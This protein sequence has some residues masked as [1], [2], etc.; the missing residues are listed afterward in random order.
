[1]TLTSSSATGNQWFDGVTLLA[2][3]T[4]QNYVATAS[5]N[6]NVVVTTNGCSSAPSASTAVTVNPTP[7][8][9]TI[10]PGGPTTFCAG[11][12]VTLTSSSATGN[13]WF[14][15][16]T[17]LAGETNQ[18]YVATTSGSYNVVVTTNGCPSAPS[19]S[20]VVTVNPT[21]ATPTVTPGGPTTFCAGGSV[22]LTSS[23]A[24]GNQW[25]NG[26]TLLA[27]ETNQ[28]YVATASG[29]YNVVVTAN[30]CPSAPSVSTAV[31]VNPTPATPT[32]TPGGPTTF[33]TGGSVTL[34]SSSATGNQ[35]FNGVT[36]LA[37]ETN[38][39]YVATT[40]GNYNV[41]VTTSGCSSAP[42]ASTAVTVNPIPATP[43]VTPGGPTTFCAGGSVT[44]TSSSATGNQWFNGVTLLVGETNQNYVATAS[45]NY[46]VVVTTNGCSSA[47]SASTAVTVNPTPATPTITPGG[48]TTFCAG[49]SV[50]LTSSSATGNQWFNGLT[51]LAGETN[52]NYVATTSGNYNV[53]VTTSGCSSA[54]SASTTVTVNPIP[55]TPTVTPGGPTTF[56]AGGSVT[57]TSSSATGNQ[58][59]DGV[60]PLAG[61]TNQNYVATASGNY[62]VVVTTNGCSSAPSSSTAVTVNP[63]PATPTITP[64]GPTTFCTGGSVTLTS[65]SATGNQWFNG[66][67]LLVGETNQN[68]VATTT[69]NYNVV[70]TTNGCP[71][72]PS[73]STA[74]T[75]NP[76]PA[77]PTVTPGGPTTFC[78]GGSVTLTSS[79]A[80]G[81]QWFDGLTPLAGETNQNYVA[82]TTSNYNVVVTTNGCSSAASASTSVTVNPIP[83]TPTIT[84]GGP[85]T[86]CAGGSVTLTSSSATGNQWFLDGNPIGGATAQQH[87]ANATG[88]YT[89]VVTAGGCSS[90]PSS[91]TAVTVNPIP[92]TPTVT[93]D[94]PTTFCAGGMVTLTSS[95]ATGNQWFLGG[96]PIGGAT[97]Q[98][99]NATASGNYTVVVTTNGCS[100]APSS[101]TT[102]TVNPIPATP[103]VTPGGPTTFCE[104]G[105]VTLTSSSASGNQ[106]YRD[107][108]LLGGETAQTTIA[109]LAGFY[110][111]KVTASGCTS[112]AAA[113]VTVVLLP[114]PDATITVVS[115]M[116][117]GASATASVNVSCIGAT[118]VWSITNGIITSGAGT[119][120]ITFT[121]G[122]AGTLTITVTVTNA[123]GCSDT[124]TVNVTVQNVVF[125]APPAFRATAASTTSVNLAWAPVQSAAHYEIHR[126]TDN[127]TWTLRGTSATNTFSEAGLTP[128]TTYFYKVRTIKAD[129]TASAFSVIDPATTLIFTDEPLSLCPP[130]IVKAIHITQL[131]TAVNIARAAI[132]LSAF[133]FTDPA[134]APG[135]QIKAVHVSE[136]RTA[137]APVLTAI[138]ITPSYTDP[139]I[140]AF[141]TKVK[142]AHVRELRDLIK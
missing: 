121:A 48:P 132:G 102:V 19:A 66:V 87:I 135:A 33:C 57:L 127:V 110:T 112:D 115:P 15:G 138:S 56:C 58:W 131:R 88:N 106:W 9:P 7:A 76:I 123:A 98:L 69:G 12:S 31:T 65:S 120:V 114:K 91:A 17:L 86:F 25:F 36:P 99:F 93:P 75:V 52:Q 90:A 47:P 71:S 73:A 23:S 126:S 89:V 62:N 118:F 41:V 61:E 26:V 34:T 137:L 1:V 63:T 83:A 84:P 78:A 130:A 113:G 32:I 81:N 82:T 44:L 37:G 13:Q 42:S 133:A 67:T 50:T 95:S 21:P 96:N 59:F 2:G 51:P 103:T 108:V 85:T 24:T 60:T 43:T 80:T 8:T 54:P 4:N 116:F 109:T 117:A 10:T 64:G 136:L 27:G 18:N 134:L 139:T 5:G 20:T 105:S 29:N 45:G 77:T 53:V 30:G 107:G 11:G 28:N 100:S 22:T 97:N 3:E 16:V 40:S 35:W 49:G 79:S 141:V 70:V 6:Y 74:V 142:N 72:A 119:P 111:V 122:S 14:D 55:A 125:G 129:T 46:N 140:T 94:G 104:G 92:A 101:A 124:K 39:N 68:Y 38:Q 128:S